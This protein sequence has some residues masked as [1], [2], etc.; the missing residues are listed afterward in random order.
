M[1]VPLLVPLLVTGIVVGLFAVPACRPV[2]RD[3]VDEFA[4]LSGIDT[5]DASE[6]FVGYYLQTG[7]RL[8]TVLVV[9][10]FFLPTL[11][12][13]A[14]GITESED[15]GALPSSWQAV[16]AAC[17]IGTIWAELALARPA[18]TVRVASLRPRRTSSY[19]GRPLRLSPAVVGAVG[20]AVWAGVARLPDEGEAG[21]TDRA[22]TTQ[23]VVGVVFGLALPV[24]VALTQRWIVSRPQPFVLPA[25]V[26]A[27]DA[28]RA[29][30]VRFVAAVGTSMA[31]I[32]LAGGALQHTYPANG[33]VD[34]VSGATAFL[35]VVGAW[36]YWNARKPGRLMPSR[37]PLRPSPQVA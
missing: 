22:G 35:S 9:A 7:R 5:T 19:L 21:G 10:A 11:I 14:L 18:G 16:L 36:F 28:V 1:L 31:L 4:R 32:N 29:S 17:L 15:G 2:T 13:E 27:D 30:S 8:R 26:A 34:V 3:D 20:A 25:L 12:G 37:T 23:I 24:L 6:R 33:A